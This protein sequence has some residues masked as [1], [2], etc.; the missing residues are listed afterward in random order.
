M[1]KHKWRLT[2]TSIYNT[3]PGTIQIFRKCKCCEIRKDILEPSDGLMAIDI[4]IVV[5]SPCVFH[6]WKTMRDYLYCVDTSLGK[7]QVEAK[8]QK[9]SRC[10]N[11][12]VKVN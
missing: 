12:K 2:S 7:V 10:S 5:K 3:P 1:H 8:L 6:R 11:I 9:C 4:P